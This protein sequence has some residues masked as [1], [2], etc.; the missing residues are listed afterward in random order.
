MNNGQAWIHPAEATF[1]PPPRFWALTPFYFI[2]IPFV[3]NDPNANFEKLAETMEFEGGQYTQVRVTYNKSAGDSPDDFYVLLIDSKTKLT[4]GTYY[5]VTSKL[6]AP[7]G[8]GP[9]KF[10]SLDK[11]KEVDGLLLAS[12][13]RTFSME[14][15]K[16]GG[17][18]RYTDVSGV[19]HLPENTVDLSIPEDAGLK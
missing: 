8:P 5:S 12:G 2:G 10:I 19:K 6:V 17:Q 15:G 3:F 7:N 18:M 9:I 4:K 11:L 14:H 16:I 13:H 1:M